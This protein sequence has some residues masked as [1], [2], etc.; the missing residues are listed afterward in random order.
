MCGYHAAQSALRYLHGGL[1]T[2]NPRHPA[3]PGGNEAAPRSAGRA[4]PLRGPGSTARPQPCEPS[5]GAAGRAGV[6]AP[7]AARSSRRAPPSK[8]PRRGGGT[9]VPAGSS[10]RAPR[11]GAAAGARERPRRRGAAPPTAEEQHW[12]SAEPEL[13][14]C[15]ACARSSKTPC[16][17]W[18]RLVVHRLP[19]V[20]GAVGVLGLGGLLR[21]EAASS[22]AAGRRTRA[23]RGCRRSPSPSASRPRSRA[24][25][26]PTAK[27]IASA[28][29]SG[30]WIGGHGLRLVR[31][32]ALHPAELRR[33]QR[34]HL[35]HADLHVC[36][37]R[38]AAR[39][40]A[41]R[42][43]PG[44]RA[45]RRSRRDCSGMPR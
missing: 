40:A 9:A 45:S 39:C 15:A 1:G 11:A 38:A 31:Q 10:P 7:R 33:V 28:A 30:W 17:P 37:R 16:A 3:L 24:G 22:P 20:E 43:S 42:R 29:T 32:P 23:R 44:W 19:E 18:S 5:S 14:R 36:C 34:R 21:L 26:A 25:R 27:R 13:A 12:C 6:S 41:S 8:S 2:G 35:D 4:G